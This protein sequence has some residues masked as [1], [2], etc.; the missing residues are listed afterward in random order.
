MPKLTVDGIEVE[1]APGATV[2]QAAEA[3]GAEIP[4]F[5]YHERLSIA[6]NCRMCLVEIEKSPKPVAS[7]AMPAG[8]GMVVKT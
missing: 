7:C 8:D 2:L 1:V 6:G 3:A 4:R 5:C